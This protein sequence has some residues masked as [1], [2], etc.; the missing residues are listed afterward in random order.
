MLHF[1]VYLDV[2]WL[3]RM[4]VFGP[5]LLCFVALANA[6][7]FPLLSRSKLPDKIV[8]DDTRSVWSLHDLPGG[9]G[10]FLLIAKFCYDVKLELTATNVVSLRCAAEYL[11]MTDDFGE[12]NLI[13]QTARFLDEVLSSWVDT[14]QALETCEAVLPLSEELHIV[15]RCIDS[16]AA[17]ACEDRVFPSWPYSGQR[18]APVPHSPSTPAVWNGIT[19]SASEPSTP[20]EDWWFDDVAVLNFPLFKS[21]IHAVTSLGMAPNLIAGSVMFYAKRYLPLHG[22][23]SSFCQR[24]ESSNPQLSDGDQTALVEEI[25]ELLPDQ[26]GATPTKFLLKLLKISMILDASPQCREAL[27]RRI[28]AQ[29]EHASLQDLLIPNTSPSV[30]TLHDVECVQRIVDHFLDLIQDDEYEGEEERSVEGSETPPLMA[31]V[32][33]L[34]DGYLAEVAS[35]VNLKLEDFVLL[36]SSFPDYAR[37]LDDGIYRAIDIYLKVSCTSPHS[38]S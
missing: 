20:A 15:S 23:R 32:A 16:L 27:E 6:S 14:V 17:K 4:T 9:A 35:D 3:I 11:Q 36:A 2:S 13:S 26:K 30:E 18:G 28:G 38:F 24:N 7:Q 37:S 31:V 29:L 21:L 33:N 12:G 25:T 10:S 22:R 34:L 8:E 5:F 1:L 19:H